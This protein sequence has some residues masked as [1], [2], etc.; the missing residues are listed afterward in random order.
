MGFRREL[1]CLS[2]ETVRLNIPV[3]LSSFVLIAATSWV[4][5]GLRTLS[6][7]V[8]VVSGVLEAF[9]AIKT[10]WFIIFGVGAAMVVDNETLGQWWIWCVAGVW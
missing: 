9:W 6:D 10:A 2:E 5:R 3:R 4:S 7:V 1:G 8:Y